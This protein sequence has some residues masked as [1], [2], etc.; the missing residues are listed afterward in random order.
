MHIKMDNIEELEKEML[1]QIKQANDNIGNEHFIQLDLYENLAG[2]LFSS[3]KVLNEIKK[4]A[5]D[6]IFKYELLDLNSC[7]IGSI[8]F[9]FID[10]RD[11]VI[12]EYIGRRYQYTIPLI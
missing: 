12:A 11:I 10:E 9:L 2:L 3:K 6:A 5:R 4:I 8:W 7:P 1:Q